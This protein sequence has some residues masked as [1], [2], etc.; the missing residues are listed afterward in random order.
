M[1]YSISNSFYENKSLYVSQAVTPTGFDFS[2]DGTKL[3]VADG[4]TDAV[5]QYTLSTAWDISTGSYA[6]KSA[7]ISSQET[8][9]WDVK[10]G[11]DGDKMYIVG[12]GSDSV[13]QYTLSTSWDVSTASYASKS[14]DISATAADNPVSIAF[15]LSGGDMYVLTIAADTIYQYELSTP[16]DISTA[17]V[18]EN[19]FTI[20]EESTPYCVKFSPDGNRLYTVG[21][22]EETVFQYKLTT[23][24]DV[25]TT[26]Y[27]D[28]SL[29]VS[30]EAR[31]PRKILFGNGGKRF[32]V[33]AGSSRTIFQ[34]YVPTIE[35][36]AKYPLPAFSV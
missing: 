25:S 4:N 23:G 30:S 6:S 10:F 5:Y 12:T 21:Y 22:T 11:S 15:D 14:I 29:D 19:T 31:S 13:F 2:P 7:D 26:S 33:L 17:S 27:S 35:V 28:V 9:A 34:Y 16:W 3:Y 32:Y 8:T 24:W 1:S 18:T 36:G 20:A